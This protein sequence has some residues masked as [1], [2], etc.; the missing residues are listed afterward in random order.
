M[1]LISVLPII[2]LYNSIFVC[3]SAFGSIACVGVE[4]SEMGLRT[5]ENSQDWSPSH[6]LFQIWYPA[7][8]TINTQKVLEGLS[9]QISAVAVET[10]IP[11]VL[12]HICLMQLWTSR[13]IRISTF[14]KWWDLLSQCSEK[15][16]CSVKIRPS[17]LNYLQHMLDVNT[18]VLHCIEYSIRTMFSVHI[19]LVFL[20][21]TSWWLVV[22]SYF[23]WLSCHVQYCFVVHVHR[24]SKKSS[25]LHLAPYM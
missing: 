23:V 12:G 7:R 1:S 8:H 11:Q 3:L 17:R 16:R 25:T 22:C 21:I 9:P 14:L 13:D 2:Y 4:G 5:A 15:V 24:V 6:L 10:T 19:F 18:I 20:V